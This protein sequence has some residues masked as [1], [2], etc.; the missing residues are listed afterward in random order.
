M[1]ASTVLILGANGRFGLAAAQAFAAA[2]WQ[3][4]AQTRRPFV[5]GMPASAQ[6]IDA[7]LD[8]VERLSHSAAG[9]SVVVHAVNPIYTR[10][11]QEAL[12]MARAGMDVAQQTGALFMLPGNVYNFGADM[13]A[14]LLE[15]TPQDATTRKGRLRIAIEDE[16]AARCRTRGL[17]SVVLRAGD[18]YGSGAGSWLDLV[19]AKSLRSGKLVYPGPLYVP[20]AWAYLPDLARAFV[21]LAERREALPAFARFHF[22]GHTLDGEQLLNAV[23]HAARSIGIAGQRAFKRGGLPWAML[24]AGS[25]LVPMWREIA[26]MEYLWRVPH[27][28]DG[29]ALQRVVGTL[30]ATPLDESLRTALLALEH[31]PAMPERRGDPQTAVSSRRHAA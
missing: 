9:A 8:D 25:W 18:F 1:T 21:A 10:W 3:V 4:L 29:R 24:R 14:L 11:P 22:A 6:R 23:E 5:A 7:G 2:G 17:R 31:R 20:H 30:P 19:I 28:L 26:E 16:M 27:V 15:N 12:P 13:P